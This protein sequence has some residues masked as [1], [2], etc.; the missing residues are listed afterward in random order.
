MVDINTYSILAS[1]VMGNPGI[2]V[3]VRDNKILVQV[4]TSLSVRGKALEWRHWRNLGV[5]GGI[6]GLRLN[7]CAVP[8]LLLFK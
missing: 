3:S 7:Y 2:S 4:E 1:G 6:V 8:F 5:Q